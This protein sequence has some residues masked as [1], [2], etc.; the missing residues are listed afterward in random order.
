MNATRWVRPVILTCV[1]AM[2]SAVAVMAQK[3]SSA[4]APGEWAVADASL[5]GGDE[6]PDIVVSPGTGFVATQ[7]I[8]GATLSDL[9]G[10]FPFGPAFGASV[11]TATAN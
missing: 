9:G 3:S 7:V 2:M 4:V 1:L 11:L 10:G 6:I 8:D 5:L